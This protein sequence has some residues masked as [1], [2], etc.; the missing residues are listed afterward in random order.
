MPTTIIAL[1]VSGVLLATVPCILACWFKR[2]LRRA[3]AQLQD[4]Q[5]STLRRL[6]LSILRAQRSQESSTP[7]VGP[8]A[9]AEQRW[10]GRRETE[11]DV[12]ERVDMD[13]RLTIEQLEAE[14]EHLCV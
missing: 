8:G 5:Q 11:I 1:V 13:R 4:E 12:A 10:L 9:S 3:E 7:S 2:Q 14:I 6:L